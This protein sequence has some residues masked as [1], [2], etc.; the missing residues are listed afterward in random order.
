MWEVLDRELP[1]LSYLTAFPPANSSRLASR[2]GRFTFAWR[3][4]AA[5]PHLH[6]HVGSFSLCAKYLFFIRLRTSY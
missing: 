4:S 1:A 5:E 6:W 3:E 2:V